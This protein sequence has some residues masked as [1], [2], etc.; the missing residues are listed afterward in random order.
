MIFLSPDP[1][2]PVALLDALTGAA[3]GAGAIVSFTGA[4]RGADGVRELW[5]DHHPQLTEQAIGELAGEAKRRFALDGLTIVHR[6][7]RVAPGEPIVFVAA[8]ARH[9]RAAFDAVDHVMDRLKTDVP[10]WKRE[11]S[12]DGSRWIEARPEDHH[13]RAR[14]EEQA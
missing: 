5:L 4:V 9:R 6:I 10:L 14:W 2:D 12:T 8:A 3:D 1:I 13:D 11:T 7:G